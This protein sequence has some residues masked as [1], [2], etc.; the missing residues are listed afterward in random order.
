MRDPA[1]MIDGQVAH[2]L[3]GVDVA[4][5]RTARALSPK[6]SPIEL[7]LT[8]PNDVNAEFL[9]GDNGFGSGY[10]PT[11][12]HDPKLKKSAAGTQVRVEVRVPM[13]DQDSSVKVRVGF[14]P[15]RD[16]TPSTHGHGHGRGPKDNG[17]RPPHSH[18]QGG[19]A[20]GTVNNWVTLSST[21]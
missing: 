8:V 21:P 3:V 12:E 7:I 9:G 13:K 11:I 2:V 19:Y 18:L 16:G 5:L 4:K 1:F 20:E 17:H 6:D 14:V 10:L 15:T